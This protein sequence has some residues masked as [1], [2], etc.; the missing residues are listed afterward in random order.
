MKLR[1]YYTRDSDSNVH[2]FDI[3]TTEDSENNS[4]FRDRDNLKKLPAAFK[5]L[6]ITVVSI[7]EQDT[8]EKEL[9]I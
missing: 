3:D 2:R 6:G 5:P 8:Y 7:T 9:L 1:I 4:L